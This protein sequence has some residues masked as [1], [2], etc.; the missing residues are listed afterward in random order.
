MWTEENTAQH[1]EREDHVEQVSIESI[2]QRAQRCG[3]C[4]ERPEAVLDL[5]GLPLTGLYAKAF[6]NESVAGID[7]HLAVCPSCGHGQL[8]YQVRPSLLYGES[9]SFRT[10]VSDTAKQGTGFFL[11]KLRE[12]S[13]DRSFHRV[14]DVGCNDL[15]LLRQLD[16]WVE[17]R[18]GIDPVWNAD[19]KRQAQPDERDARIN[20]IGA[21]VEEVDLPQALEAPPDL[22]LCRHTLEHIGDPRAALSKLFEASTEDALFLFEV[23]GFE[24][25]VRRLRFDHVF[26]QHV[27]YFSLSSFQRLLGEVGFHYR[28]HWVN[29]HEWGALVMAFVKQRGGGLRQADE[30]PPAVTPASVQAAYELFRRQMASTNEVLST[31]EGTRVYGYGAAAMLPILAYHLGNDLSLLT[32]VLDDDPTK[33]GL[34]YGNLPLTIRSPSG[35]ADLEGASIFLTAL[36]NVKPILTKLLA[37]RPKHIIY[38]LHL[39]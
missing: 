19:E 37:R 32:A 17:S 34:H 13:A 16:G 35:V 39:I 20:V 31:F 1:S 28:A 27:Q 30:A 6:N 14:L 33:D 38:P 29:Y 22:V 36:D 8:V 18:V 25:L 24:A 9:Y 5:P 12:L 10:S 4:G 23:P 21:T 26:H 2:T 15:H 3:V 11:S 7:Q